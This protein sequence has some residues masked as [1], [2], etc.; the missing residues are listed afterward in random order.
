M[1]DYHI[2]VLLQ[3]TIEQLQVKPGEKYIDATLGGGGHSEEI[4]RAGGI[5]LGIDQDI[6]AITFVK[7]K[8]KDNIT[9]A[10]GN[11]E[12]IGEIARES[13]FIDVSG[14]LYDLGISSHQ[15][16]EGSRGFSFL[17]EAPLDMRMSDSLTVTAADLVNGLNKGELKELFEKYGEEHFARRIAE[18]IVKER[19]NQKILTTTQLARLVASS[20]PGGNHKVHPATKVFQSLRIAVNDELFVLEKSL[21]QAL[22]LLKS[23][24]RLVVISF[25]SLEDRIIKKTFEKWEKEGKGI[26]MTKKPIIPSEEET[27]RNRRARSSKLR[28]FERA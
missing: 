28:V 12:N 1:S 14:V 11:F 20:Y 7:E 6:D 13:G 9:I 25:H 17:K 23:G 24:G 5:V 22:G 8:L 16:D 3:E 27:Q 19:E 18:A 10:Q 4:V 21:P 26:I 15:V 2:S